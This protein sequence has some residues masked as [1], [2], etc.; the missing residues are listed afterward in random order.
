MIVMLAEN[1]KKTILRSHPDTDFKQLDHDILK[2]GA[3]I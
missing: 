3:L 1:F 2:W